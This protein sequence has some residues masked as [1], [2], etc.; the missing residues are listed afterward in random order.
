LIERRVSIRGISVKKEP[1]GGTEKEEGPVD[2]QLGG[3]KGRG[4][5]PNWI[6]TGGLAAQVERLRMVRD[7]DHGGHKRGDRNLRQPGKK[8][9][10]GPRLQTEFWSAK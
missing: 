2:F 10:E 1:N 9:K 7:Y 6:I 5:G 8:G 3:R 4:C